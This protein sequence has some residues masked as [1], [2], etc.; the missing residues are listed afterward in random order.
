MATLQGAFSGSGGW[1]GTRIDFYEKSTN[2][3]NNTSVVHVDFYIVSIN[4]GYT[5]STIPGGDTRITVGTESKS[6]AIPNG[7]TISS[8]EVWLVSSLDFTNVYHNSDGTKIVGISSVANTGMG[9]SLLSGSLKLTNIP[10]ASS[11]SCSD[12]YIES[13][14]TININSANSAFRHTLKYSFGSLSGTIVEKTALTSYGW[15]P[16][17]SQFYSKIPNA[18]QGTGTITC[19]TYNGNTLLGTKT[20]NFTARVDGSKCMPV[21][22]NLTIIDTNETT[23]ALTG[24]ENTL[25]KYFSKVK[26]EFTATFKNGATQQNYVLN[27]IYYKTSVV[28]LENIEINEFQGYVQDSR[29]IFSLVKTVTND[30]IDYVKLAVKSAT[31]ERTA[32]T[33]DQIR[34]NL[35][36][37]YFNDTFGAV[38]NTLNLKI[39][40]K[41]E[42]GEW[43]EYYSITPNI[44]NENTFNLQ[45]YNLNEL[46]DNAS[47]DYQKSYV[48]KFVVNDKLIELNQE[49]PLKKGLPLMAFGEDF[50]HVYGDLELAS[51]NVV[52]DYSVIDEWEE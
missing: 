9:S 19:E 34:L 45:D 3:A 7:W 43:S 8:G 30:F 44:T 16:N 40:Y 31:I 6:V 37:F 12:F 5:T 28:T 17:A 11:V 22:N 15:T 38:A 50:V 33:E 42:Y 46:F 29:G 24:N 1:V 47:F 23:K 48:F 21:L 26:A 13:S 39:K 41:E 10:R 32:P 35:N 14:T 51:G 25:I 20:C 52:L 18:M 2:V 4:N 36:G 27:N 49:V